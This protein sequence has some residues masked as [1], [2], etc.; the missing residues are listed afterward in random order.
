MRNYT[1]ILLGAL[2]SAGAWAQEDCVTIQS[3]KVMFAPFEVVYDTI[4][5][6][7][8]Y[9]DWNPYITSTIPSNPDLTNVGEQFVLVVQQPLSNETIFSPEIVTDV[10]LPD[11]G[12]ASL[13]YAFDS[14]VAA[15][16][17]NPARNQ[18]V[19]EILSFV[20]FYE[21]SETFCG[22]LVPLLPLDDVQAG[23]DLQTEAL[24]GESFTRFLKG[25]FSW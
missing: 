25:L 3:S 7:E 13:T 22:P 19:S 17:G 18:D 8:S 23:F 4:I 16:L 9:P 11:D 6:A 12:F 1:A 20:T 14:P 2:F 24:A 5:D 21:T 10:Q 15:A